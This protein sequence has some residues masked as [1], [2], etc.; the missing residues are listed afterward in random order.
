MKVKLLRDSKIVHK[1]GEIVEVSPVEAQ[2]L[3]SVASAIEVR[4]TAPAK[5]TRKRGARIDEDF[6]RRPG[7]GLYTD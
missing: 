6:D 5:T 2:F 7:A 1:A 4:E 3:I